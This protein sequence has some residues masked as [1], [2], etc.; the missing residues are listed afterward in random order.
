M[1]K[2]IPAY[3]LFGMILAVLLCLP[4]ALAADTAA[5]VQLDD[6]A[7]IQ[8]G[9][10]AVTGRK[11]I[12]V[13]LQAIKI[14]LRQPYSTDPKLADVVV[15]RI[16]DMA[17]SNTKKWLTCGTNRNL[18]KNLNA[19]HGTMQSVTTTN[20]PS[21]GDGH[22]GSSMGCTS[23]DCYSQIADVINTVVE[24]QPGK[25]LHVPVNG[26]AFH[27]LLDRLPELAPD[28]TTTAPAQVVTSVA[29][30]VATSH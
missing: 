17:G 20:Q 16:D 10:I 28:A 21:G 8:L 15:C 23:S 30:T 2:N 26:A 3:P 12:L 25:Y 7:V 18:A 14:S 6:N 24:N 9:K 27:A 5:A 13:T 4:A 29:P 19:L 22:G 1:L 11:S